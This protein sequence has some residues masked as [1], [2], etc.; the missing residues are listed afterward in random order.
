MYAHILS[1]DSCVV[2]CIRVITGVMTM[3]T[4]TFA[5]IYTMYIP[6]N[7]LNRRGQMNC[8]IRITKISQYSALSSS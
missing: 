8:G 2:T 7:T 1:V 4:D 3:E 5:N 6:Y